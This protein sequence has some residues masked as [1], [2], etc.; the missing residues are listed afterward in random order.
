METLKNSKCPEVFQYFNELN[1]IPRCSGDEKAVSDWLVAFAEKLGLSAHQDEAMNVVIKKP[2]TAG[3]EASEPVILQG[4]MDMVCVKDEGSDHD[5]K[6]DPI[7]LLVSGDKITADGTTLG[8]DNGVAVSYGL[9]LL[10]SKDIPH[11]PMEL[12][13]TTS[14]ETGMDGAFAVDPK[15]LDGRRLINIDAEEE[16]KLLVSCAG[17]VGT[18]LRLPVTREKAPEGAKPYKLVID[19]LLGGHSG[20]EIHKQ[21]GNANALLGRILRDLTKEGAVHVSA[22]HGGTKHNAIP[23]KAWADLV[24]PENDLKAVQDKIETWDRIFRDELAGADEGVKVQLQKGDQAPEQIFSEDTL[25]GAIRILR[26]TPTGVLA[27]SMAIPGLVQT[28]NNLGVV[29]TSEEE[30]TFESAIRS[31]VRSNKKAIDDQMAILAEVCGAAIEYASDYP[32]WE[33]DPDSKLRE[34]FVTTHEEL[35]GNKPE[36]EAIHAGLECGLFSE[37]FDGQ[38]DLI[39]LGPNLYDVHTPKESM[40]I[41]SVEKTYEYLKKVLANLK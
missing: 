15:T 9:A 10:A 20:M 3:Y 22:I 17:G 6:K 29:V 21:R 1:Q 24:I 23:A 32:E 37:K 14:E 12:L 18:L 5:F 39:S 28:S 8:A 41:S 16:G 2:G 4:H 11:P 30:I 19:G 7:T 27:M 26:L 34:I 33:Y 35:Y 38:I 40:S 25:A 13:V 31:S 36:I